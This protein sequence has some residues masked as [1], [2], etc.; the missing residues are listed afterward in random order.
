MALA[1]TRTRTVQFIQIL[2]TMCGF[3]L[4]YGRHS[5]QRPTLKT[6]HCGEQHYVVNIFITSLLFAIFVSEVAQAFY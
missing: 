1:Y 6:A 5:V 3:W 2:G 4:S